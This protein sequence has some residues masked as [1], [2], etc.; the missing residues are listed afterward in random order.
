MSKSLFLIDK[1]YLEVYHLL[2]E[3]DGEV[4]QDLELAISENDAQFLSKIQGYASVVKH[5]EAEEAAYQT[6]LK[7]ISSEMS[8]L[9]KAKSRLL[10]S[11]EKSMRLRG[12]SKIETP[13]MTFSF[14]KSTR[15]F[16]DDKSE[17]FDWEKSVPSE[18]LKSEVK[19]SCD[20]RELKTFIESALVGAEVDHSKEGLYT[21]PDY[22]HL[23]L[24]IVK[25]FQ[26]K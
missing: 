21:L 23:G 13:L 24:D 6:Y 5:I 2:M 18:Y 4:T 19:Y 11:V 12:E 8:K 1:D 20:K 3:Q 26:S 25:N 17:D 7:R 9:S 10:E 16:L 15:V 14:R 22:P